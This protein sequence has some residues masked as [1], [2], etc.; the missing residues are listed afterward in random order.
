M[1]VYINESAMISAN[2]VDNAELLI[3]DDIIK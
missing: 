3:E 2:N 1:L